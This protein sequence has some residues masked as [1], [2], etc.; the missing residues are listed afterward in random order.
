[1][2]FHREAMTGKKSRSISHRLQVLVCTVCIFKLRKDPLNSPPEL[3]NAVERCAASF[4]KDQIITAVN[5]ILPRAQACIKSD[6][7]AFEY[8]LKSFKKR[9]IR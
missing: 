8:K 1:M 3:V 2:P 9:F 7:G 4:N 5:D 6:G